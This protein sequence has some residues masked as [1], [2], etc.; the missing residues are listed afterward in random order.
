MRSEHRA[1]VLPPLLRPGR[2]PRVW[3]DLIWFFPV[4]A[5]LPTRNELAI[6]LGVIAVVVLAFRIRYRRGEW[7]LFGLGLSMGIIFELGGE[8]IYKTQSWSDGAL[9]GIP[10]WLPLFW[11]L[12]FV[13]V[14]R[15]G[16]AV[17]TALGDG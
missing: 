16:N 1:S 11:G 7:L 12:G 14:R 15:F 6:C 10:A 3:N 4:L 17:L 9:F 13:F 2:G 5:V 8:A